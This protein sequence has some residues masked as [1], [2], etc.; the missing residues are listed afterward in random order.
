MLGARYAD[1]D[2]KAKLG[3]HALPDCPRNFNAALDRIH[4]TEIG[5]HPGKQGSFS[6]PRTAQEERRRR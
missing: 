6:V 2:R 3:P 5:N 4:Q 1:R